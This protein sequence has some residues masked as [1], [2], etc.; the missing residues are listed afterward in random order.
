MYDQ[1]EALERKVLSVIRRG[2]GNKV[3]ERDNTL[4]FFFFFKDPIELEACRIHLSSDTV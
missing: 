2:F 4:L 1:N 3:N